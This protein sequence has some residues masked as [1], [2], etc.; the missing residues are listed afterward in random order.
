MCRRIV[1][2]VSVVDPRSLGIISASQICDFKTA[3][4]C[5]GRFYCETSD[6]MKLRRKQTD[7][8]S[9]SV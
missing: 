9:E 7:P 3:Q 6:L 2:F 4:K 8:Q 1:L 5:L